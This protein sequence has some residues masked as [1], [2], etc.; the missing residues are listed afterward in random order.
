MRPHALMPLLVPAIALALLAAGP[1]ERPPAAAAK[2]T[3]GYGG[4]KGVEDSRSTYGATPDVFIPYRRTGKGYWQFF[5]SP[6][7]F[8]GPG[9]ELLPPTSLARVK[10]GLI[11]PV[12]EGP[13]SG[14]G[15]SLH[16]GVMLAIGEANEAGGF[17]KRLPYELVVRNDTGLWGASSNTMVE[18]AYE[19]RVWLVIGSVDAA[20]SHIALRVALKAEVPMVNTA[21][22]DPTMT[23]TAIPWILRTYPD[24]RQHGYRLALL[25]FQEEGHKRVAVLR[26]NDKFGRMGIKE[27]SDAARRLG[28]PIVVE[29]RYGA[30]DKTFTPQLER[31]RRSQ[32]DAIVLWSAAEDGGRIV[33]EM[34]ALGMKHPVYGTDRL[35]SEA[36]LQA[37][38]KAAEGVVAT[39]PLDPDGE[40]AQWKAFEKKYSDTYSLEPDAFAAFA[41]DGARIA[42][43]SIERG[44][45]NRALIWDEMA[46]Y[47]TFDGVAGP[48]TFDTTMNN[49]GKLH[50]VQVK[51]GRFARI[52][53]K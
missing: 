51:D 16:R 31:I 24:D 52:A 36:F 27:F 34:R 4:E 29:V 44:G 10:I 5:Q 21:S 20:N 7:Q 2:G 19:E 41:Y 12:E 35:V 40:G 18:L 3:Q 15:R 1:Q 38:G 46:K 13:D 47:K 33:A 11:A 49:L 28:H 14:I 30:G 22:T 37:A 48:M 26:V 50:V 25:V 9:R 45:L 23:E 53:E 17:R 6:L 42:I 32:V 39:S 43:E 8:L